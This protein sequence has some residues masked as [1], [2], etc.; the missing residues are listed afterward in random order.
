MLSFS[1]H[2]VSAFE[3]CAS[4]TFQ[5]RFPTTIRTL[6]LIF[7]AFGLHREIE[8]ESV[9]VDSCHTCQSSHRNHQIHLWTLITKTIKWHWLIDWKNFLLIFSVRY[10]TL[11]I[12]LMVL[13]FTY[14][15]ISSSNIWTLP[16]WTKKSFLIFPLQRR[17]APTWAGSSAEPKC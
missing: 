9:Y 11:G 1:I 17:G 16:I 3:N 2:T 13:T 4:V 15:I 6:F 14:I 5:C 7:F 8:N 12:T 10:N